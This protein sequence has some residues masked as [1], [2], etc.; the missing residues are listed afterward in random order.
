MKHKHNS[1]LNFDKFE[2]R[3]NT[4]F[5][6]M[7]MLQVTPCS[8][9]ANLLIISLI[10]LI[11]VRLL[12]DGYLKSFL[13]MVSYKPIATFSVF[14]YLLFWHPL[15]SIEKSILKFPFKANEIKVLTRIPQTYFLTAYLVSNNT[16]LTWFS[17]INCS[18]PKL[19]QSLGLPI[20]KYFWA[21]LPIW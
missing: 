8:S 9:H 3:A 12:Y 13:W 21:I 18:I 16:F 20:F 6:C 5:E 1:Q 4:G 2:F 11:D 15:E 10:A 14:I 7:S 19:G 17:N